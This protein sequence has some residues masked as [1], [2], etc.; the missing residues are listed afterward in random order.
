MIQVSC[1]KIHEINGDF[2]QETKNLIL[3]TYRVTGRVYVFKENQKEFLK[4]VGP[5][6]FDI[7]PK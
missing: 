7:L 3:G 2:G 4:V 5:L 6:E 1:K